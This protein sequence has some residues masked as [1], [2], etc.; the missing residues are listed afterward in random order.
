MEEWTA[1]MLQQADW[2]ITQIQAR[3][4]S[5][6]KELEQA[7]PQDRHAIESLRR[8][9]RES[10]TRRE[11]YGPEQAA[12]PLCPNCWID[13]RGEQQLRAV[14]SQTAT[15]KFRCR[16]EGCGAEIEYDPPG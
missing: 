2:R 8:S 6:L 13:G 9:L 5:K 11:S 7:E 1:A 16:A 4:K 10:L 3:T 15:E 12:V 14:S